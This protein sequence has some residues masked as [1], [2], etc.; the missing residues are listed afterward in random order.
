MCRSSY[1]V[2]YDEDQF[3]RPAGETAD[4][5]RHAPPPYSGPVTDGPLIVQSD[6][7]LLLEIDHD[8]ASYVPLEEIKANDPAR[9]R[10][11]VQGG[12][13][14]GA[15]IDAFQRVVVGSIDRIIRS[16]A[17]E[18]VAVFCHGGVV[19]AWTCHVLGL[20][21]ALIF[22]VYYTSVNRFLAASSGERNLATLNE[23]GHLRGTGL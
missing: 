2:L 17:G 22:D 10:A 23:I 20:P 1:E 9:W 15:D 12:L 6:K 5:R 16:H 21:M 19:N 7:T 4:R 11:L 18:R 14:E 8:A 3:H 13:Y